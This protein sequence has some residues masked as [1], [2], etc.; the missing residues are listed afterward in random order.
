MD[1]N[2]YH[3]VGE[4]IHMIRHASLIA[5]LLLLGLGCAKSDDKR[6]HEKVFNEAIVCVRNGEE[7]C[8]SVRDGPSTK[9]AATALSQEAKRLQELRKEMLALGSPSKTQKARVHERESAMV[10]ASQDIMR[11]VSSAT[12]VVQSGRIPADAAA[13]WASAS[14]E[15][16][17]AMTDFGNN[18]TQLFD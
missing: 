17:Q 7:A 13:N 18:L 6:T 11:A 3:K 9:S 14:M 2:N 16:G 15:F 8:K 12:S 5:I 10:Q 4:H 1:H